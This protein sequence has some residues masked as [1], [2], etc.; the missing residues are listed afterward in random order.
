M[1]DITQINVNGTTYDI[2]DSNAMA[3]VTS[4]TSGDVL[5]TDANGQA[6]D[7]GKVLGDL[8]EYNATT[9]SSG[10]DAVKVGVDMDLLWTNSSP[11]SNFAGQTVALDLSDYKLV[12][13]YFKRTNSSDKYGSSLCH[14]GMAS[15]G[16]CPP[17]GAD[18][19]TMAT[20]Y[21]SVNSNGIAFENGVY[22]NHG[23]A[24][25]SSYVDN[26]GCI[27]YKIYGIR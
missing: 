25:T 16:M 23:G 3:K 21:Y 10:V 6:V 14:V 11:T 5:V 17:Q 27:P 19:T 12:L 13:V 2:K 24:N 18:A 4:A 22:S 9:L 1:A 26:N 15:N 7:S 8:A 20:R